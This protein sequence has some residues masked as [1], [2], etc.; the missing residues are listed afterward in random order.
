MKPPF[1]QREMHMVPF[2]W[3]KWCIDF[4]VG[5]PRPIGWIALPLT[6]DWYLSFGLGADYDEREVWGVG[7]WITTRPE[8]EEEREEREEAEWEEVWME[9]E[10]NRYTE[11]YY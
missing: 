2:R 1:C 4:R 6:P 8:T 3:V 5:W 9:R 10:Q 11:W 7:Q